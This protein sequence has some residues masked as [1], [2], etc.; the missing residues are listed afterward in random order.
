MVFMGPERN[1][2]SYFTFLGADHAFLFPRKSKT[3]VLTLIDIPISHLK[4]ERARVY[5]GNRSRQCFGFESTD[6]QITN[7]DLN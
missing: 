3:K 1:I 5:G 2:M 7:S 6:R 4:Q